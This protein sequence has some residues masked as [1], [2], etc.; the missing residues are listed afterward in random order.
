[1]A[2]PPRA[3]STNEV[4]MISPT[5]FESNAQATSDNHFMSTTADATGAPASA[6]E[7]DDKYASLLT[8]RVV[9]E[10]ASLVRVLREEI[11][12]VVH[13]FDH[14]REH[15]TPDAVF[16]NNWFS[17]DRQGRVTLYPMR[18]PNRRAERRD[19]LVKWL[20]DRYG[21]THTTQNENENERNER[22]IDMTHEE[23]HVEG[24]RFLEGT[25]ALVLDRIHR[26][27]YACVSERCDET[28]AEAWAST[29]GYR[30]ITFAA[31]D[32]HER[33]IYHT[34]VMMSVGTR[35]AVV[36]R[37]SVSQET[38]D[39]IARSLKQTGRDE[40]IDIDFKQMG[41]MCGNVLEL[42]GRDG[43]KCLLMSRR[44]RESFSD[45]QMA[46]IENAWDA[47]HVAAIPALEE[48][49]GGGVRC[50]VAELF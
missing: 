41:A 11:G 25:G 1:M 44:A 19:D 46:Q 21:L 17:T 10:H 7:P 50:C 31:F 45:A 3:Q 26:V 30:L 35:G 32:E 48:I 34:N 42:R 22:M 8:A 36:C 14:K 49:G 4:F 24:P 33:P 18:H 2:S 13:V 16:P 39:L 23:T 47:V 28:L 37:P 40:V 6:G 9:A 12:A 38:Y 20:K 5:A 29:H 15:G 43:K 27:A